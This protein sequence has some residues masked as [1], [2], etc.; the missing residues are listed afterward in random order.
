[1][2]E[3]PH[4]YLQANLQLCTSQRI[5]QSQEKA[6]TN[7]SPLSNYGI[8]SLTYQ[9]FHGNHMG[10]PC[11]LNAEH[12]LNRQEDNQNEQWEEQF[13]YQ[14]PQPSYNQHNHRRIPSI[15]S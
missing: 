7:K 1:M 11:H 9:Q 12:L 13:G 15:P 2:A 10:I 14:N 6:S 3:H 5:H 8:L 4:L